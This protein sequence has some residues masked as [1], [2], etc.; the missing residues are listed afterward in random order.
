M[1]RVS[2]WSRLPYLLRLSDG[3]YGEL[4]LTRTVEEDAP[5]RPGSTYTQVSVAFEAD[6]Q[7]DNDERQR[8]AFRRSQDLL[9]HTNHLLRWYR[10]VATQATVLEVT[11][12]QL[13]PIRFIFEREDGGPAPYHDDLNFEPP[14]RQA[15]QVP[16]AELETRVREGVTKG[17]EPDVADLFLLDAEAARDV[18]RFREAVLFSWSTIDSVFN[19]TY[20]GLVAAKLGA[21]RKESREFLQGKAGEVPL[22]VKMTAILQLLAGRSLFSDGARWQ[23]LSASDGCRNGIIHTGRTAS[24]AEAEQALVV[25]RWVVDFMRTARAV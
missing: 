15:L 8:V 12:V 4:H 6:P 23:Q 21:E 13:S 20:D 2:A 11:R 3:Q 7:A 19:T 16:L 25:A 5:G 9:R 18:G 24:E 14:I 22:K 10:T 1:M 17:R